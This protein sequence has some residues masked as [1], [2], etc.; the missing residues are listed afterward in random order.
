MTQGALVAPGVHTGAG[1]PL[2]YTAVLEE[3]VMQIASRVADLRPH[4]HSEWERQEQMETAFTQVIV[5]IAQGNQQGAMELAE[6]GRQL[7]RTERVFDV[8]ENGIHREIY[9][10]AT[11]RAQ[12]C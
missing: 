12:A 6:R 10:I 1:R 4:D 2:N 5:L 7:A 9:G 3:R 8:Q 11:G